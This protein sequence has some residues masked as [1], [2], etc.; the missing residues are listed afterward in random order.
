MALPKIHSLTET[1]TRILLCLVQKQTMDE[2]SRTS[3]VPYSYLRNRVSKLKGKNYIKEA[4]KSGQAFLYQTVR[5]PETEPLY[6]IRATANSNGNLYRIPEFYGQNLTFGEAM[7]YVINK[8]KEIKG[9]V[10]YMTV[11]TAMAVIKVRSHKRSIGE[12]AVQHPHESEMRD[13]LF[14]HIL[15]TE[16][17]LKL[18]KEL[19]ETDFLWSGHE[20]IWKVISE[21]APSETTTK[22]YNNAR[23]LI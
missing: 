17:E 15:Q 1:D 5:L 21:G 4:G 16:R 19:Y 9:S 7:N 18:A 13:I 3:G 11:A 23:D 2:L 6:E 22:L 12:I 10:L 20:N 8:R 14:Q